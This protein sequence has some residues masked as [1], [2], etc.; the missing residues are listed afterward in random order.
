[1]M[2]KILVLLLAL[3]VA[4]C[5]FGCREKE[6]TEEATKNDVFTDELLEDVKQMTLL[7]VAGPVEGEQMQKVI[8]VLQTASLSPLVEGIAAEESD[9]YLLIM[10]YEDGT[11]QTCYVSDGLVAFNEVDGLRYIVADGTAFLTSFLQAFGVVG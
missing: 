3:A 8:D 1:M 5:L 11:S 6:V 2:R 9:A 4:M 10:L 7:G